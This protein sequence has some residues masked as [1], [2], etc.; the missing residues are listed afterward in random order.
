MLDSRRE[1]RDKLRRIN[2]IYHLE[3]FPRERCGKKECGRERR[4]GE[5][6]GIKDKEK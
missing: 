4:D 3:M 1:G 2:A 5:R 6:G